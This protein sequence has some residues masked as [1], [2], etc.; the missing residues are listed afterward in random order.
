MIRIFILIILFLTVSYAS[1]L[2]KGELH[3]QKLDE[4]FQLKFVLKVDPKSAE[5]KSITLLAV[6]LKGKEEMIR[7]YDNGEHGDDV[8][9]DGL[10]SGVSF[11][12][13]ERK[14]RFYLKSRDD[15]EARQ[16]LFEYILL[17]W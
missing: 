6:D 14:R 4:A 1:S 2:Q 15:G 9:G 7:L 11:L 8:A 17:K 10:F 13:P 12:D 3:I 5:K 16:V